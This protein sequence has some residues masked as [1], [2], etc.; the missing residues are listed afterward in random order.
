M[1]D[2]SEWLAATLDIR[3]FVTD[4]KLRIVFDFFDKDA[5]GYIDMEELKLVLGNDKKIIDDSVWINLIKEVD[6]DGDNQVSF[7][8]F[9]SMMAKLVDQAGMQLL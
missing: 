5:S 3:K 1:I 7:A 8:E 9:T 4:S 6:V 2:Y